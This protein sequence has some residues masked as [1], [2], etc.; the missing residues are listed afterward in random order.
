M[1]RFSERETSGQSDAVGKGVEIVL[2]D[3]GAGFDCQCRRAEQEWEEG[4]EAGEKHAG[5]AVW[6]AKSR[7]GR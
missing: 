1:T 7:K 5:E 2:W 3:G 4:E 6:G